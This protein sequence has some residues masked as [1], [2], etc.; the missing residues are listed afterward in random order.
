[1][2]RGDSHQAK[3]GGAIALAVAALLL[4]VAALLPSGAL[5]ASGSISGTVKD[6]ETEEPIAGVV[7]CAMLVEEGQ[8]G[9][10]VG[11][12]RTPLNGTYAISSLPNGEYAVIFEGEAVGY[13]R[14][15]YGGH[16]GESDFTPV[17]VVGEGATPEKNGELVRGGAIEGTVTAAAGGAPVEGATVCAWTPAGVLARCTFTDARGEYAIRPLREGDYKVEFSPGVATAEELQTQ[18]FSNKATM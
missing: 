6:A 3:G 9:A 2:S 18:F 5:A 1:M 11:C 7:V 4:A 14:Q 8:P 13:F 10:P 12:D 16:A 15:Y 17:E